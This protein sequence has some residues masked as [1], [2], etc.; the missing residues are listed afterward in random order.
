MKL[1]CCTFIHA[2]KLMSLPNLYY[3]PLEIREMCSRKSI[4][5]ISQFT[6]RS[7]TT[8]FDKF[9]LKYCFKDIILKCIR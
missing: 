4:N 3:C 9:P 7:L 8:K 2:S 6:F 1:I 5:F